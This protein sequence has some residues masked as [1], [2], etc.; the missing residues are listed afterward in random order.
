MIIKCFT[1]ALC[2]VKSVMILFILHLNLDILGIYFGIIRTQLLNACKATFPMPCIEEFILSPSSPCELAV[3]A[4]FS[5]HRTNAMLN[6]SRV[7]AKILPLLTLGE[8]GSM[9]STSQPLTGQDGEVKLL[10][11][12]HRKRIWLGSVRHGVSVFRPAS[13]RES[14][15][16]ICHPFSPPFTFQTVLA[17]WRTKHRVSSQ[18]N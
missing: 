18:L 5:C 3:I 4:V 12:S 10:S 9:L 15:P 1:Y 6:S 16:C 8:P 14:A 2:F 13:W 11:G 17:Q 7:K